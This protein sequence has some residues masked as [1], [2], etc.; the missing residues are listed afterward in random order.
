MRLEISGKRG[1]GAFRFRG[2]EAEERFTHFADRPSFTE[3]DVLANRYV[4]WYITGRLDRQ[5]IP[6]YFAAC[7]VY[8]PRL[9]GEVIR[10]LKGTIHLAR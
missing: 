2:Y 7:D 1:I 10:P 4:E 9:A 6:K 8:E 3:V 5:T